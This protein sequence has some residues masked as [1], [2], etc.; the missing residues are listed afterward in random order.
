MKI[1]LT[2]EQ[3]KPL[4]KLFAEVT[5]VYE[6]DPNNPGIILAQIMGP[7]EERGQV[8]A[9]FVPAK[10][11]NIIWEILKIARENKELIG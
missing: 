5:H 7:D 9:N 1:Q 6:T 10:W 4:S 2:E 11:A 3:L 8:I